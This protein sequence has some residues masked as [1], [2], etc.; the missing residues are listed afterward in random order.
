MLP[1]HVEGIGFLAIHLATLQ[2]KSEKGKLFAFQL[3]L[4]QREGRST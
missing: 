4:A 2:A 1:I 3:K